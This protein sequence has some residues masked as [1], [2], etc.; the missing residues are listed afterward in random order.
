MVRTERAANFAHKPCQKSVLLRR[1]VGAGSR[2]VGCGS[3]PLK[4]HYNLQLTAY[5]A[6][7]DSPTEQGAKLDSGFQVVRERREAELVSS[8]D[9][10]SNDRSCGVLRDVDGRWA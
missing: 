10:S 2:L 1:L 9:G 8:L 5:V 4:S 7:H 3:I 6:Q